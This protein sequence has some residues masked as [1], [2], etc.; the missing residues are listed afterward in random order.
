MIK[1]NILSV[2][3]FGCLI[4]LMWHQSQNLARFSAPLSPPGKSLS[5]SSATA[6]S[7]VKRELKEVKYKKSVYLARIEH[8]ISVSENGLL[9]SSLTHNKTHGDSG[10]DPKAEKYEIR[11]GQLSQ[12][13][14]AEL[15]LL[16]SRPL[17]AEDA[18]QVADGPTI[19]LLYDGQPVGNSS[20]EAL[21]IITRLNELAN[22]LPIADE[23]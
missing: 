19:E 12:Q 9:F 11:T 20:N 1:K 23:K 17:P 14:V 5:P 8:K 6:N 21:H 15:A 7:T 10:L 3:V 18:G 16:F 2:I 22:S 4:F 13:E